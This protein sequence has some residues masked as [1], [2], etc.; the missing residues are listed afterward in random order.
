MHVNV[1]D[2]GWFKTQ[3]MAL[4]NTESDINEHL[5]TLY[6]LANKYGHITEF[7]VRAGVSTTAFIAGRLTSVEPQEWL[8]RGNVISYD[9]ARLS[10]VDT[11]LVPFAKL[12][13]SYHRAYGRIVYR[14]M[15]R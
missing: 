9:I 8:V 12:I 5:E 14:H 13:G 6:N 10:N 7:G 1:I 11:L 4:C 15:A 3:Y 2:A